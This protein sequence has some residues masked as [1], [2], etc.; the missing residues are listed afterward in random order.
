M[1]SQGKELQNIPSSIPHITGP[2]S[3]ASSALMLRPPLYWP[4]RTSR[5]FLRSPLCVHLEVLTSLDCSSEAGCATEEDTLPPSISEWLTS[6]HSRKKNHSQGKV[7]MGATIGLPFPEKNSFRINYLFTFPVHLAF[8]LSLRDRVRN[9]C[10]QPNH[11]GVLGGLGLGTGREHLLCSL[12]GRSLYPSLLHTKEASQRPWVSFTM[13]GS[14]CWFSTVRVP[15]LESPDGGIG[16]Q[17][18]LSPSA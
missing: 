15:A 12:P 2:Q 1:N 7:L 10:K 6:S 11:F 16:W 4:Q 18:V 13:Q 9:F 14:Q 8:K 17:V 5:A 3:A